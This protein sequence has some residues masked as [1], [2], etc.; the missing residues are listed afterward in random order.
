MDNQVSNQV[1]KTT[2]SG[3]IEGKAVTISYENK[4]GELPANVSA[5][6]TIPNSENPMQSTNINVSVSIMGNKT[7]S[8]EGVVVTGDM[9]LLLK[10]I[11]NSIQAILVTPTA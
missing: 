10:G 1:I 4:A 5:V 6:C 11:E 9:S 8:V 2:L 3:T 7:I